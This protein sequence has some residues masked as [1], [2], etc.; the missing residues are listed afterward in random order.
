MFKFID[1]CAG[2]GGFHL[3]L[4]RLGGKCVFACEKDKFAQKTYLNWW[5]MDPSCDLTEIEPRNIPQYDVLA[6]GFPCMSFSC[7]GKKLGFKD[8]TR[9]T[10]I[11]NIFSIIEDTSPKAVILENVKNLLY[12]DN[13][14]TIT[15]ITNEL[16]RLGYTVFIDLVNANSWVPQNRER[17]FISAIRTD[18][19]QNLKLIV[20]DPLPIEKPKLKDILEKRV[21]SKYI[22]G[23]KTWA[24]LQKH[25]EKH[26]DSG[27]FGYTLA[28]I[29]SASRTLTSRYGKDGSEILIAIPKSNPRKLT[30]RECARLMGFPDNLDIVV[31]NYQAYKQFGNAVVPPCVTWI[32]RPIMEIIK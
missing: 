16:K 15:V 32:A 11:F 25:K 30:P 4:S 10:I 20:R 24:W 6:A 5:G 9:G 3:G 21:D 8:K 19:C 27:G 26:K 22:L 14:K 31:S 17:V 7:A 18:I 29:N 13:K 2:I 1:L 12:H 23:D 28:N